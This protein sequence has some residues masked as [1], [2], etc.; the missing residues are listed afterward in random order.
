MTRA[1]E[2]AELGSVYDNGVLSNRNLIINGSF[3]VSQRGTSFTNIGSAG[4]YDDTYTMDRFLIS[5]GVSAGR[6]TVTQD[7]DRPAG[8]SKSLK[9]A[10]T[11]ADTSIAAGEYHRLQTKFEG[12]DLKR[13]AKG[14]ASA[15]EFTL[16]FYCKANAAA[17]YV[18]ELNDTDNTRSVSKTFSVTTDWTRVIITFPADTASGTGFNNDN[19]LS[20]ELNWWFHAGSTYSSG[21]LATTWASTTPANRAAGIDSIFDSTSRTFFI[22]GVQLEVGDTATPFEH[23]SFGD[24]LQRCQRYLCDLTP[25][26]SPYLPG[27][28][29]VPSNNTTVA[30]AHMAFPVQM[31]AT[32]SIVIGSAGDYTVYNGA[33]FTVTSVA[34]NGLS[35]VGGGINFNVSGGGLT[36]REGVGIFVSGS[37][38]TLMVA[39]L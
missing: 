12:Q 10:T 36:A 7:T 1:R 34:A 13:F 25:G 9:I 2:L 20:M 16:S 23:R 27:S 18:V 11:T 4:T 33:S 29:V 21:T 22:T 3:D 8:F 30:V 37:K 39:E 6:C 19:N 31:R 28:G 32:P 24:E 38:Q 26:T 17:T 15:K 5:Q 35:S 14:T